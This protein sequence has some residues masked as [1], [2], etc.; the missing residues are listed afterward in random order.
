MPITPDCF[1]I[2]TMTCVRASNQAKTGDINPLSPYAVGKS[3]T[4]VAEAR[5]GL[6]FMSVP[7]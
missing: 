7:G 3:N 2:T 5:L 4:I 6:S 1:C